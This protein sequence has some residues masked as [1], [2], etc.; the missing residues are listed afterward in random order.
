[1]ARFTV[2]LHVTFAKVNLLAT[3]PKVVALRTLVR[4]KTSGLSY[5]VTVE[6]LITVTPVTAPITIDLTC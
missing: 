4:D 1:M 2:N 5:D 6:S 3:V